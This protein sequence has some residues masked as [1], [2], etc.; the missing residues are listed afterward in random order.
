MTGW[1]FPVRLFHS[2]LSAGFKRRTGDWPNH[3]WRIPG[4]AVPQHPDLDPRPGRLVAG[5]KRGVAIRVR[6]LP[7]IAE[8][9]DLARGG[10]QP[11][12]GGAP[13]GRGDGIGPRG[14]ATPGPGL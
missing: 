9:L 8:A 5:H 11:G 7:D 10:R 13:G 2:Q 3:P 12:R 4:P 14:A 6:E 1:V